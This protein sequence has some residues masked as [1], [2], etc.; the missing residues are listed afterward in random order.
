MPPKGKSTAAVFQE[1]YGNLVS[2]QYAQYTTPHTL[3]MALSQRQPPIIVSDG[4]LKVWF[5]KYRLP[6]DAV[7][8]S[9]AEELNRMYGD[10]LPALAV[11]HPTSYRLMRALQTRTPPVYA[12]GPT[13]NHWLSRYFHMEP[14]N[15]AAHLELKYG[16]RIRAHT[17]VAA[18]AATDLRVWLRTNLKV[19]ASKKTCQA[20]CIRSWSKAGRL[21]S[22]DAIEDS[23]GDG[24]RLPQYR[25]LFAQNLYDKL[26]KALSDG[27]PRVFLVEPCLL[28]QWYAKYHPDS[29]AIRISF[30]EPPA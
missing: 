9:S 2:E 11:Q 19:D 28:R 24:L 23:I 4:M 30:D 14:I 13:I 26:V 10:I 22:I 21:S 20:W 18:W 17:A 8:V 6:S 25:E 12:S 16:D 1:Q 3:R 29:G 7:S 15:S 27:Q 5:A